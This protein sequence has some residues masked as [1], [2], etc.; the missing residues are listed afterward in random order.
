MKIANVAAFEKGL[1]EHFRTT[2]RAVRE[3]LASKK[4]LNDELIAK[5]AAAVA[6]FKKGFAA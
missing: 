3:E 4:A 5:I 6:D 2:A 1:L